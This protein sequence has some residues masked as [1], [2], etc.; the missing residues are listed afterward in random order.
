MTLVPQADFVSDTGFTGRM[1]LDSDST[2]SVWLVPMEDSN[3][4]PKQRV[5]KYNADGEQVLHYQMTFIGGDAHPNAAAAAHGWPVAS[6]VQ[7]GEDDNVYVVCALMYIN[8]GLRVH[9]LLT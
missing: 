9:F 8:V 3:S 5:Y 2:G 1:N 4:L 7:V 6:D